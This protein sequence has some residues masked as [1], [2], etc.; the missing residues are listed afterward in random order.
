MIQNNGWDSHIVERESFRCPWKYISQGLPCFL[1]H[2]KFVV[3]NGAHIRFWED[4][5]LGERPLSK[6][7]PR[8][9]HL[10][11]ANGVHIVDL[12]M[13]NSNCLSWNF[14]FAPNLNDREAE[15]AAILLVFI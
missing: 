6:V 4:I 13:M 10:S 5:W 1:S 11:R 7:Y 12:V 15:I 2:V 14:L 9:F 8:L 3:R